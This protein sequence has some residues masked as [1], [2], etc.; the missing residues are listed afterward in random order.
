[1]L[2]YVNNLDQVWG[3]TRPL[4]I[5]YRGLFPR[6]Q[7]GRGMNTTHPYQ[8]PKLRMS[9]TIPLLAFMARTRPALHYL[10]NIPKTFSFLLL[11][12]HSDTLRNEGC[13]THTTV[14]TNY[15][16]GNIPYIWN[17][18]IWLFPIQWPPRT[19]CPLATCGQNRKVKW[20][21]NVP[22]F[23]S[24]PLSWS[25][26]EPHVTKVSS[27]LHPLLRNPQ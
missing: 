8:V 22:V 14:T 1:M 19:S 23:V 7:C 11:R 13:I 24:A 17:S 18:K 5:G 15:E 25:S 3:P 2:M 10:I 26:Q 27:T 9:G 21:A 6:R 12:K 16:Y 4:F 20:E